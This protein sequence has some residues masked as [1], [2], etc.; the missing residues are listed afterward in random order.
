LDSTF[1]QACEDAASRF[2][3][4]AIAVGAASP[5]G[6]VEVEALGCE[7]DARFRIASVTKPMTASLAVQLL[8]LE[9]P[10]GVWPEEVRVHHLLSH[11]SGFD[12][13]LG[14]EVRFGE[15][16]DALGAAVAELGAVT[17]LVG[18][19]AVWSYSNTG[20]W[21]AGWL[22][23]TAA[24]VTFEDAL[25]R[26]VLGPAGMANAGF[27]EPDLTGTGPGATDRAYPRPR[28]PSGG[29]VTD[30]GDVIRFGRWLLTQP[31]AVALRQVRG[32]PVS[33]V[34]GLGLFG[35]R[36]GGV[37]VWGHPGS[38]FGFQS[39]LL[40]VPDRGAVF[41]G[42][43]SS[44]NGARALAE[45]EQLWLE[46]VLGAGRA[47]RDTVQL[48]AEVLA[49]FSGAY[50][51]EGTRAVF[52]PGG[53]GLVAEVADGTGQAELSARPIGP[54]RFEVVGGAYDGD[55]FDFPLEGFARFG[56]QLLPQ[57]A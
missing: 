8:E 39:N 9:A 40:F 33:G 48:P 29:V 1:L 25:R 27:E 7:L 49:S 46:R 30:V 24:G 18:V 20:Y 13:E 47:R 5:D 36:I 42:L 12:C 37:E 21:L 15:G 41:A 51:N 45:V 4:P 55:R 44:G 10:T 54:R 19:D 31:W 28:R 3:V 56:S 14:D 52:S 53:D 26:Y 22:A 38:T 35:E 57:V 6:I 2:D 50:G 17:R 32:K 43:T 23:A 11:M 16:D 34:Y